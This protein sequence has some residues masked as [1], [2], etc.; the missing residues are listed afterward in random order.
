MGQQPQQPKSGESNSWELLE[1]LYFEGLELDA[2]ARSGLLA[3]YLN[4]HQ[5]LVE[6][7]QKL[8]AHEPKMDALFD[9]LPGI[10]RSFWQAF[11]E[12]TAPTWIGPYQV[13]EE[14]GRG[15]MGVVYKGRQ[16]APLLR[17]V[18][19]KVLPK[20]LHGTSW[21]KRFELEQKSLSLMSH[22]NIATVH[23]AGVTTA[24]QPFLVME[25]LQG[26]SITGYC[27]DKRLSIPQRLNL[28]I[29]IC[30]G[31]HHAH[32]KGIIHRDLKPSN[33]L[34]VDQDGTAVPKIIDFGISGSLDQNEKEASGK[35]TGTP[36]Y[37]SPE[38]ATGGQTQMDIR[39]DLYSLG[40]VLFELLLDQPPLY[41]PLK[42]AT[43]FGQKCQVIQQRPPES[44]VYQAGRLAKDDVA[45]AR[46]TTVKGLKNLVK[47]EL[48]WITA[49]A[50]ARNPANRYGTCFDL[51]K[52]LRRYQNRLPVAAAGGRKWYPVGK[53]FATHRLLVG[54]ATSLV[55][56]LVTALVISLNALKAVR[57]SERHLREVHAFSE[58]I[59]RQVGPYYRGR[60]AKVID[61]LDDAAEGIGQRYAGQPE[62]ETSIRMVLA[63]SYRD[64]GLNQH[65]EAQFSLAWELAGAGKPARDATALE[66]LEERAFNL[67][68]AGQPEKA[69]KMYREGLDAAHSQWGPNHRVSLKLS[70]GLAYVL[71]RMNRLTQA[72][73]LFET[74]LARQRKLLPPDHPE[75]LATLNNFGNLLLQS[76][77]SKEAE[78]L[79][80]QALKTYRNQN[81]EIDPYMAS[82]MHNLA[83]AYAGLGENVKAVQ[84]GEEVLSARRKLLGPNHPDS[85]SSANNLA[86]AIGKSN[87]GKAVDLLKSVLAGLPARA[88]E[89]PEPLR[90]RHNLGHFLKENKAYEQSEDVLWEVWQKRIVVLGGDHLDT[91]LSQ[92]TLGEVF[93]ETG[94]REEAL[95]HFR[96]VVNTAEQTLE[97]DHWFR[98]ISRKFLNSLE[99][100]P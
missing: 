43:G 79:L 15:G 68:L 65:A 82:V 100:G 30:E 47:G 85:L 92:F 70:G 87:P 4:S 35:G 69:L 36:A 84:L 18:A 31:V 77:K 16:P 59:F 28:F 25:L 90:V 45:A 24:G 3:P 72:R 26:Q 58:N 48:D 64:L 33:I 19:I 81:R 14:I 91:L 89:A 13:I 53:W 41:E 75:T 44:L 96:A 66:I 57:A 78:R 98:K 37:M 32:L 29:Q 50:L 54:A 67:Y 51:A 49:K 52:D 6:E 34:V 38:Q 46:A 20:G 83:L 9:S 73:S 60:D 7:L 42:K 80:S 2:K 74:T 39:S 5:S 23:D 55:L 1:R 95:E 76:D 21:G 27:N 12:E 86:S 62:L 93:L 22:P 88:L 99:R 61:L 40:A 97:Q 17:Q 63:R 10:S 71:G 94:R 11:D 56:V 8:W